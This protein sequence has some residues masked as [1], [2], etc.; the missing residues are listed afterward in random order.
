MTWVY[1]PAHRYVMSRWSGGVTTEVAIAPAGAVYADRTLLWRVSSASVEIEESD[2]TALPDYERWISAIAGRMTLSHDGG[3]PIA[4]SPYEVHQFDGA[5]A[6]HSWGRCTD[7]NLML[8]KGRSQGAVRSVLVSA[9]TETEIA[10]ES[11][12]SGRFPRN[13][14]LLFCGEG[15]AVVTVE[16]ERIPLEQASS[17]LVH[18]ALG[19]RLR[20]EAL[21]DTALL[22][23]EMQTE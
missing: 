4:L 3:E 15:E 6:T 22:I 17:L 11:V 23:A 12:P 16:G 19:F 8:R 2:F 18:D 1:L 20:V 5:A 9:G 13:E 10:F 21:K 7:F 14:L